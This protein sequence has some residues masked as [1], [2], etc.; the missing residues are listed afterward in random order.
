MKLFFNNLD[1]I[2]TYI[3]I[4]KYYTETKQLNFR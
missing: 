4:T 1:L 3:R 2:K